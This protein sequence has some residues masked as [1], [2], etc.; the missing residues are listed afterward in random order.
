MTLSATKCQDL[1]NKIKRLE[2]ALDDRLAGEQVASVGLGPESTSFS[3]GGS[4]AEIKSRIAELKRDYESGGC[5]VTL[6]NDDVTP[7]MRR[8]P[9]KFKAGSF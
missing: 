9:L 6:G 8:A 1:A 7:R 2:D 3:R 4:V 5:A